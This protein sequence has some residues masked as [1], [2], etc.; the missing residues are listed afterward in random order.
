VDRD[1]GLDSAVRWINTIVP[2][3]IRVAID[4]EG[5]IGVTSSRSGASSYILPRDE[6]YAKLYILL[7]EV[8]DFVQME[9]HDQWPDPERATIPAIVTAEGTILI[10]YSHVGSDTSW[11]TYRRLV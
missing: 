10:G 8:Q 2:A 7:S 1:R 6:L 11:H 4:D 9:S 5:L 3:G